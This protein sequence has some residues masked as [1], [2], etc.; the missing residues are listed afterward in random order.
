MK[1]GIVVAVGVFS[2]LAIVLL[3]IV[4]N[5]LENSFIFGDLDYN[6]IHIWVSVVLALIPVGITSLF[7]VR[8]VE[9][10]AGIIYIPPVLVGITYLVYFFTIWLTGTPGYEPVYMTLV[11]LIVSSILYAT[12]FASNVPKVSPEEEPEE[13]ELVTQKDLED[14]LAIQLKDYA[15]IQEVAETKNLSLEI[16]AKMVELSKSNTEFVGITKQML[17]LFTSVLNKQ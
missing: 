3:R 13:E 8:S 9:H 2:L 1:K 7:F 12:I 4:F 15:K 17:E 11:G 16:A 10:F 14:Y 5:E 6:T